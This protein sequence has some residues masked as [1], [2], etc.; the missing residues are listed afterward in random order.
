MRGN[1]TS[2]LARR[3]LANGSSRTCSQ[4]LRLRFC[5]GLVFLLIVTVLSV[6]TASAQPPA[7]LLRIKIADRHGFTTQDGKG[8]VPF[9][10]SYYRPGQ[11]WAPQLWKQF[12][13]EATRKDFARMKESGVNCARVFLTYGSFLMESNRVSPEGLA[14]FDQFLDIA[15]RAGI[16][17]MPTGPDH[18]EGTP[19]W[20][21]GDRIADDMALSALEIF[22]KEFAT[23]YRN[24][25][26]IFAYDLR[27]EP[28]VAW[29]TAAM[30]QKWKAWCAKKN[31]SAPASPIPPQKDCADCAQ[32]LDFQHFREEI[33]DEWTKRQVVAIKSA[34]PRALVTIGMIQ[35]SVPSVLPSSWHYAAFRPE[36]QAKFLDFLTIHFYPLA[37]GHYD[38]QP[39]DET[40]NLAYLENV[41]SEVA[42]CGKP[43]VVGEFGWYGGGK[44]NYGKFPA[45]TEEQQARWCGEVV[46]STAGMACGW[47]NWGFY[48][49]PEAGDVSQLTGL[50]K[51]D[52]ETKAWGRE[53]KEL[54][55]RYAGK[56]LKPPKI[57]A[58]P[59]LN[60]DACITSAAA[61]A[62]FNK[63]YLKAYENSR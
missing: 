5:S 17:V 9:G 36:R 40:K 2:G 12:D 1:L 44:L 62:E 49:Q 41:V 54:S 53:F 10:V 39:A 59:Q 20:A 11:G 33:A 47:L 50:V 63:E 43:V 35:W 37:N 28:E 21:K 57:G 52:G 3:R 48:D 45:A 15:E 29:D 38:Y 26:V 27:N 55:D 32:L 16:Y 4:E 18:W 58:R 46:T 42:R 6:A 23:R 30:L 22:W 61:R 34:D 24:R 25:T 31:Y 19:D 51:A 56:K 13:P 8:F 60:W 7:A 14:K